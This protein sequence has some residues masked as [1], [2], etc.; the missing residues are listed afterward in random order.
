MCRSVLSY[1]L[2]ALTTGLGV[3]SAS[4]SPSYSAH[5]RP[6]VIEE[7]CN[8][9]G[10]GCTAHMRYAPGQSMADNPRYSYWY[11][12]PSR[13]RHRHHHHMHRVHHSWHHHAKYLKWCRP[14]RR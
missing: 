13:H 12:T 6:Y 8:D 10:S 1:F 9:D 2:M 7:I 4:A 3:T 5:C 14:H 11:A